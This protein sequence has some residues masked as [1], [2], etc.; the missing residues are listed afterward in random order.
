MR[1][2]LGGALDGAQTRSSLDDHRKAWLAWAAPGGHEKWENRVITLAE[3]AWCGVR[4]RGLRLDRSKLRVTV[5]GATL[6][7]PA[8][9]RFHDEL[10]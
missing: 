5:P 1:T 8:Y 4:V 6:Q 7:S 10:L 2:S 9:E 3:R